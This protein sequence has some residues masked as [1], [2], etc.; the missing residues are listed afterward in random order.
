VL[1]L[2][3]ALTNEKLSQRALHTNKLYT[4]EICES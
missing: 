1:I 4:I 2:R 3:T